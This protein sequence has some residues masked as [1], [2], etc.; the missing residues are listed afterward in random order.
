MS[1]VH[2]TSTSPEASSG[3][4]EFFSKAAIA[5]AAAAVAGVSLS[6]KASAANG[7][8]VVVGF[9]ATGTSNTTLSGGTSFRVLDGTSQ[10]L[11]SVP[12]SIYGENTGSS[13]A[14]G[15]GGLTTGTSGIGVAGIAS[16]TDGIGVYGKSGGSGGRGVYGYNDGTSGSGV[17]GESTDGP[18]VVGDGSTVDFSASGSGKIYMAS[19][20]V[21]TSTS[22]A[23]AGTLARDASGNMWVAVAGNDWRKIA[24]P[25]SAGSLHLLAVPTRV[26]DSRAGKLPASVNPKTPLTSGSRT[27]NCTKN[28][29]GVPSDAKG[30][31]VNVTVLWSS[32]T[33]YVAVT[34]GGAG[35]TGTSTA[36][37]PGAGG[38]TASAVTVA[39]STDAKID[40]SSG[41]G[42]AF[43]F[44]VDVNG[45]YI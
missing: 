18:G 23:S 19:A 31:L 28:S 38:K 37:S 29:S 1:E 6:N 7:D 4:R 30:V 10:T 17:Y 32:A 45:Y 5:A 44:I 9:A 14:I 43:D 34:P 16:G 11:L 26:Y 20:G 21:L 33:G 36:N 13:V 40:I 2:E 15:V 39:C 41:S 22:S 3:R 35:D 25:G 8:T 42:A 12:V 24:G 27:I